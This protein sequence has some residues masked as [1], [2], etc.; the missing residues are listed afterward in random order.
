MEAPVLFDELATD[1]GQRLGQITLN[2]P[3]T[4]NSLTLEMV[5]LTLD[6]L[7]RWRDDEGLVAILIRGSGEKAFCAGGDVQALYKSA[8]DNPGGPCPDAE[9][10]FAREYRLDY[11]LHTYPKPLIGWGHGIVMGGGMG[12]FSGCRHKVVTEKTRIAMPEVTIALFPDVGGS[13]FLNNLPGH[14][15]YFLAL[16]GASINA[17]DCLFT[18]LGDY[19]I[20]NDQYDAVVSALKAAP[21]QSGDAENHRVVGSVLKDAAAGSADALP[22]GN[23]EANMAEIEALFANPD[24]H[25]V[26]NAILELNSDH[27][28]MNRARDGLSHGSPLNSLLI[29]RQLQLCKGKSLADVFRAELVLATNIVRFQEFAEGVRALLIDKDRSPD[30]TYKTHADV[31]DDVLESFFK[32]P[33]SENPL[34]DLQ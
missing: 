7:A 6:Q 31:P 17:A 4:L 27:D 29:Y 12:V 26:I 20:V 23:V 21:W 3:K 33:W 30:W 34:N 1:T 16:T 24:A 25:A 11:T 8:T 22:E 18:G 9:Q 14:S 5:E 2:V 13:Y 28:W 19:F 32:A 15:G 10:F